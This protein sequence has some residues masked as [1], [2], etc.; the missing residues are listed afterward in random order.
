MGVEGVWWAMFISLV[1]ESGVTYIWYARD[2]WVHVK[3]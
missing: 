3:V 2:R 1:F